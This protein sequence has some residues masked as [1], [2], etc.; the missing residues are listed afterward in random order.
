MMRTSPFYWV[1]KIPV[2]SFKWEIVQGKLDQIAP[3]GQAEKLEVRLRSL[4]W[5]EQ[6]LSTQ[7][8]NAGH[9]E[10]MIFR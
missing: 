10:G 7:Y 1:D 8:V 3:V 9:S 4:G 6:H 2:N 5:D